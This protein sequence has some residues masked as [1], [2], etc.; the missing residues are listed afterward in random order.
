MPVTDQGASRD[1]YLLIPRVLVFVRRGDK[2]LLIKGAPTKRLWAGKYNG[3]GGHVEAGEDLLSAARREFLEETGLIAELFLCGTVIV[4][5]GDNPGVAVY[6]YY[7]DCPDGTPVPGDE[8]TLE[9][10]EMEKA[11]SLPCVEDIPPLIDLL[12][13][14]KAGDPPFSAHSYYAGDG[15]LVFE[16]VK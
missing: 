11:A 4:D 15:I 13:G 5:T 6:V 14:I 10:V 16:R 2:V 8:G 3:V 9:W 12:R 7:G 1:R